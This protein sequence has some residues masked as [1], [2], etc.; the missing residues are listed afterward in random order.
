MSLA[1]GSTTDG[2]VATGSVTGDIIGAD[3][4]PKG[5]GQRVLIIDNNLL[6]AQ[7][8]AAAL[9]Q[10]DFDARFAVPATPDHL[11]TLGAWQPHVALVDIESVRS[12]AALACIRVLGAA[13]IPTAVV[14]SSLGTPVAGESVHTG[15]VSVAYKGVP[16]AQL[17]ET[18]LVILG[19]DEDLAQ[20]VERRVL[21]RH[22]HLAVF[23]ILSHREK[24]VLNQLMDGQ[25]VEAI[26]RGS[27]ASI[28]TVRSQIKAILQKLGV[29]SALAAASM[30][31]R[32]GW[33]FAAPQEPVARTP[34]S[35]LPRA[36]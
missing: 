24:F 29:N 13:G 1:G 35:D 25:C 9:T 30:A 26:A 4:L 32:A 14:P 27:G 6:V 8:V 2:M 17:V 15:A 12:D 22:G 34:E 33:T 21:E 28:T 31:R 16:L 10:L 23:E 3:V 19:G 5:R 20:P 7:A 36:G 11:S 18:L